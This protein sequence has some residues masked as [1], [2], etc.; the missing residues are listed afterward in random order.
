MIPLPTIL[1]HLGLEAGPPTLA[2]LDRLL[3]AWAEH[4]PWE[5]AARIARHQVPAA[6]ADYARRP[7]AFFA[8]AVRLGTGGTC[9]ESNLAL[10][11][12][13][14]ALGFHSTLALCDMK[15]G[16][17]WQVDPHSACV[18]TINGARFL[19]DVGYPVPAAIRLDPAAPVFKE[20]PIYRYE[21]TPVRPERWIVRRTSGA[22][23]QDVFWLKGRAVDVDTFWTRLVRDHAPDGFFLGNVIIHK[24]D[25]AHEQM[26]RYDQSKGLV[27][28]TV[29][30]EEVVPLTDAEQADLPGTLAARFHM[31]RRVIAAALAR[32]SPDGVWPDLAGRPS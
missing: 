16:G 29:G 12:L 6:P 26:W 28:R 11:A 7:P 15:E 4:I 18:V 32:T 3:L 20:T 9:F 31:D 25:A 19:A 2:F 23:Q 13:L 1:D 30:R 22:F 5:S 24:L 17:A 21:V 8:D 10:H 14:D 27:R